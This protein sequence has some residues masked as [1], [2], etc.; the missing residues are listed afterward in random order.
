MLSVVYISSLSCRLNATSITTMPLQSFYY[1]STVYIVLYLDYLSVYLS[2]PS[3]VCFLLILLL[4]TLS[5][6][7]WLDG[8]MVA[9]AFFLFVLRMYVW[10]SV[11]LN[12]DMLMIIFYVN[13]KVYDSILGLFGEGNW[14]VYG[15]FVTLCN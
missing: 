6:A 2:D 11:G 4:C 10:L 5:S 7:V 14:S 13:K 15:I 3:I 8:Y 1:V 9:G 12:R